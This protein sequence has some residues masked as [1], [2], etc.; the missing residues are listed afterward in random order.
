MNK[1]SDIRDVEALEKDKNFNEHLNEKTIYSLLKKTASSFP[2]R[3]ALSFQI[4]SKPGS[5]SET[6]TWEQLL[7]DVTRAANTFRNHGIGEKDVI[8][9]I[10]PNCSEAAISFLA[11]SVSGIVNPINPLLE[12]EQIASILRETKAKAVITL[13]PMLKTDVAQKVNTALESVPDVK[14]IFEVDLVRYLSPPKSW[15]ASLLRPKMDRKHD[16]TILEFWSCIKKSNDILDFNDNES[17]RLAAYFH[18]GGTTGMPKVAQHRASGMIF[19]GW[20]NSQFLITEEDCL[21]CPLPLFHVYAIYPIFMS[22]LYSGA[23]MIMPTP[24]GY[25]GDG[26]FK[27]FWRLVEF[28]EVTFMVMVPTAAAQLIQQKVDADVSSLKYA[29]CGSSPLSVHQFKEF[30]KM[31]GLR[32][33]E[34][35]GMTE[36]TC[37]I[38]VNP[39][40][41]DRRVGSVG[42]R[43]PYTQIRILNCDKAGKIIKEC[44]VNEVGEVCVNNPGIQVGKTYT[45]AD[46]NK[47]LVADKVLMRTGDLGKL[48]KDGYLWITGRLKDLI[49]RGGH[50]IDPALIEEALSKHPSVALAGAIGQP[51]LEA[52]ELPCAYVQLVEGLTVSPEE[53]I[54]HVKS[55]IGEKAAVPKFLGIISE[56]PLTGVGKIFKPDLRKLAIKRVFDDA[57]SSSGSP[58][59]VSEV[60]ENSET[61]LVARITNSG[62]DEDLIPILSGY[63]F[64]WERDQND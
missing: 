7:G 16:A 10:L 9:Y 59:Y 1:F 21:I 58:A 22:C 8:A 44:A 17:D 13:A 40:D 34:G 53:L 60:Y 35:Y 23:H 3:K 43:Y 36:A 62:A 12:P 33:L 19:N 29:F 24:Q 52:G 11:G 6:F 51:D 25:R 5:S 57:L 26:V 31:T 20:S 38:T 27:N 47:G 55:N 49:I 45:D 63:I 41:G 2:N 37:M 42:L 61:G 4:E 54:D 56:M 32:I 28:W 64:G 46:K 15:I 30:Q 50:N 39:P 14:V 18:T 48:D